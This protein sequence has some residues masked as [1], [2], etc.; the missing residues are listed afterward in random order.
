MPLKAVIGGH[1]PFVR[2]TQ[3]SLFGVRPI[4]TP[5]PKISVGLGTK[6]SSL[7][8]KPG[9][10]SKPSVPLPQQPSVSDVVSKVHEGILK[11]SKVSTCYTK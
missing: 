9:Q 5:T 1:Q 8:L 11:S 7:F 4:A 2:T 6:T 10:L 3:S